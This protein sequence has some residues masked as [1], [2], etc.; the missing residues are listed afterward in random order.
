MKLVPKMQSGGKY[1]PFFANY[2]V[3]QGPQSIFAGKGE[4]KSSKSSEKDSDKG[5][6]SEKDLFGLL[7]DVDGLPNEIDAIASKIQDMYRY[8]ELSDGDIDISGLSGLYTKNIAEIKKAN[9][10]KKEYDKSYQI[11]EKNQG[12]EELAVTT[13]GKLVV[14][15]KDKKMAQ[16]SVQEFMN[17][18]DK[19]QP[20]SNSNLLWLRAHDPQFIN[21]NQIFDI[22][23]SAIGLS[24]IE[25]LISKGMSSLGSSEQSSE[26][27]TARSNGKVL[28]GLQVLEDAAA[29]QAIEQGGMTVDGLYKTKVITKDQKDQANAA[30][31]Y[32]YQ[33][34]PDN[35]KAI[36]QVHSGNSKDPMQGA[37]DTIGNMI[38]SRSSSSYSIS[39]DLQ[40]NLNLDGTK[41][42]SKKGKGEKGLDDEDLNIASQF[43]AGYGN[44]ERFTI[45][46][47]TN[48]ATIVQSNALPLVK[49]DGTPLGANATLQEVS[50]GQFSGILDWNNA[51]MGGRKIDS[52]AFNQIL[53]SDGSI[54]SIDFP[55]DANGN[56]DLRPTT[57]EA[58]NK[59]DTMFKEAGIDMDNAASRAAHSQEINQI[60]ESVGL[61]AAY[62][63]Q[64][65]IVS[66]NWRRFGVMNGTADNR[67]LGIDPLGG[68]NRL[69]SEITD[70]TK[71]DNL[72]QIIQEKTDVDKVKFDKNDWGWFEGDYDMLLEGT[73]WIP[74]NV[75]YFS[76]QAGS[77]KEISGALGNELEARQQM[78]DR[79]DQLLHSYNN[80]GQP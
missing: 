32:I 71:I 37:L 34:L 24:K 26:G 35:A 50:Q 72:L 55:V 48:M 30:L 22:T 38:M 33:M 10:N 64:G 5:R 60:L 25:E 8:H 69:L 52:S 39:S 44:H 70:E 46:P 73:I 76:A 7:K 47:G 31:K 43:L 36:L 28:Q 77:G 67:A 63:S 74:L 75:N 12:L 42:D 68:N 1:T 40:E 18:S 61:S 14:Y 80:P 59:A 41:K 20:I 58:K 4:Q 57:L 79:R 6:I 15:D 11:A 78:R 2:T 49:K 51:T 65:N 19:Y 54:R 53:I 21:N 45:N 3:I 17:N 56:P 29:Q 66:G 9:F 27:Y 13:S 62:D 23:N 16:I